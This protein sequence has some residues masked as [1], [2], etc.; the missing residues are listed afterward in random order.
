MI[1]EAAAN[2][3]GWCASMCRAHDIETSNDGRVWRGPVRTPLYYPDAVT[4]VPGLA[5]EEVLA[6]IDSSPGCS[7]KDSFADLDL[8]A[9]GFEVLFDAEWIVREAGTPL[10]A[11]DALEWRAAT[12]LTEWETAW[13]GGE[14]T[15]LF[16]AGLLTDT[17]VLIAEGR[18][19]TGAI[20]AGAVLNT[21]GGV[22]GVSNVFGGGFA[23]AVRTAADLLGAG[24]LVGYES[25][26]DLDAALRVG[27]RSLGPL[28]VWL[29]A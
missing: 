16:T 4:L 8:S 14:T 10:P 24:G 2:N 11:G 25:G 23:G 20:A 1:S 15:G 12:D 27:F 6:G 13:S 22:V 26:D 5:A 28:R 29:R 3:A 18:D 7:V 17:S 9:H 21:A 19:A